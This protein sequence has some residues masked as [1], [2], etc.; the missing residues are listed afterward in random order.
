MITK[1][2]VRSYI[3]PILTI[4]YV[5]I[6]ITGCLMLFDI[7]DHIDDLHKWMGLIFAV[8]GLIHLAINWRAIAAYFRAQKIV[9][10]STVMLLICAVLLLAIGNSDRDIDNDSNN[11]AIK[12]VRDSHD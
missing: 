7:D 2:T 3:S 6:S 4:T 8:A 5:I 12:H 9:I 1:N 11:K 10:Y